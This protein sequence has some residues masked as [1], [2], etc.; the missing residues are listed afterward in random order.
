MLRDR[1]TA[2]ESADLLATKDLQDMSLESVHSLLALTKDLWAEFPVYLVSK[3]AQHNATKALLPQLKNVMDKN[4]VDVDA[5]TTVALKLASSLQ[6]SQTNEDLEI[7]MYNVDYNAAF[8]VFL[9]GLEERMDE[10]GKTPVAGEGAGVFMDIDDVGGPDKS[11]DVQLAGLED[12]EGWA[13]ERGNEQ[14]ECQGI[15]LKNHLYIY[16]SLWV[17]K[18]S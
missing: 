16:I 18:S 14:T 11:S 4:I 2:C 8:H 9:K 10:L 7:D 13:Q 17:H 5:I 6:L 1:I 12:F 3:L 15:M